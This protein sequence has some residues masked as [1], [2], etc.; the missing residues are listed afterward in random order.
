[1]CRRFKMSDYLRAK[2]VDLK[3]SGKNLRC[4]CPLPHHQG[5]KDPS[6]FIGEKDGVELFYCFG[7]LSKGN[8]FTLL[9][10]M[11]KRT[12]GDILRQLSRQT[13]VKLGMIDENSVQLEPQASDVLCSFCDE[14]VLMSRLTAYSQQFMKAHGCDEMVVGIVSDIYKYLDKKIEEGDKAAIEKA[15]QKLKVVMYNYKS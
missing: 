10:I 5:E 11:E 14:D 12:T 1:M 13:G 4:V 8:V 9:K 7:C 15:L 2:G 6:F 3:R